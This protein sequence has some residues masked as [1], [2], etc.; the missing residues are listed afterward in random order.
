[1]RVP[2]AKCLNVVFISVILLC[3]IKPN[4][5]LNDLLFMLVSNLT[6]ATLV[7]LMWMENNEGKG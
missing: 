4:P 5:T 1:M 6:G 7:W 3:L 2:L